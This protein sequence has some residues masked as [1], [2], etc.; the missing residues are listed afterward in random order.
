MKPVPGKAGRSA[1]PAW[2]AL[3][4]AGLTAAALSALP[5]VADDLGT[6]PATLVRRFNL[7]VVREV[8]GGERGGRE[9]A[10]V[11]DV[12]DR[13]DFSD[14]PK[15]VWWS[16]RS[17]RQSWS[18]F[19]ED[20]SGLIHW[21]GRIMAVER[22]SPETIYFI[23]DAWILRRSNDGGETWTERSRMPGGGEPV[24]LQTGER[25]G[26]LF[27]RTI[28]PDALF[29]SMDGGLTW[30][31][32]GR[33]ANL[34][35]T[36]AFTPDDPDFVIGYAPGAIVRSRDGGATFTD[37][38]PGHWVG[39]QDLAVAP[40]NASIVYALGSPP[41]L[42]RSR[43]G[44]TT[45]RPLGPPAAGLVGL[46]L[47][48]DPRK[49]NHLVVLAAPED[50]EESGTPRAY[51][52]FDGGV[53]WRTG[54]SVP[55]CRLRY[56]FDEQ[57][58]RLE[59]FGRRGLYESRD[60]GATWRLADDGITADHDLLL[61]VASAGET[62][63]LAE[64]KDGELWR[65]TDGGKTW[66]RR[67]RFP[68]TV[69]QILVSP[70]DPDRLVANITALD[71]SMGYRL[72]WSEDAGASWSAIPRPGAEVDE[73]D[74][75]PVSSLSFHPLLP[76]GL[77]AGSFSDAWGTVDRGR[78]WE[79][80]TA[81]LPGSE[82]C[83]DATG[84]CWENRDA[85]I[86]VPDPLAPARLY[87]LYLSEWMRSGDSGQTWAP[88]AEPNNFFHLIPDPHVRDRIYLGLRKNAQV[89]V[90]DRAG[91]APSQLLFSSPG[92]TAPYRD[93]WMTLDRDGNLLLQP[94]ERA[95]VFF[96]QREQGGWDR[97]SL[98]LPSALITR[99]VAGPRLPGGGSV[100]FVVQQ[101][102]GLWRVELPGSAK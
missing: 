90:R 64:E 99:L 39:A 69:N 15:W 46:A 32:L 26:V 21:P 85:P 4:L 100:L 78:T 52:S 36:L 27:L 76:E 84:S 74:A 28:Y 43:N 89:F 83:S 63:Y 57:G 92:A 53:H 71:L 62:V 80:L 70:L 75:A 30:K 5:A 49:P 72:W 86:V 8:I 59:A 38:S 66:E 13:E 87:T 97:F 44:G 18:F 12:D 19:R 82:E 20:Q 29:R 9:L 60:G 7:P 42:R 79:R 67:W 48:V 96:R 10:L 23:D 40:S 68:D 102:I 98:W 2:A 16:R 101:G 93:T 77:Y 73:R 1:S 3:A 11:A 34:I 31:D 56:V 58:L 6:L 17:D 81:R 45:W 88:L 65:S 22:A 91:D 35:G 55:A 94:D 50:E 54:G 14:Y 95:N 33:V 41:F 47:A 25:P 51:E 37:I 24:R 61:T